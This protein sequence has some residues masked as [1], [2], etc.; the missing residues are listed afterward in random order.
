MKILFIKEK[1]SE[2]GLEGIASYLLNIC[3]EL[4]RLGIDYL[5]LYNARDL[6]YKKMVDNEVKVKL[7]SLPPSSVYNI[8]H[9]YL[10]VL[11]IRKLIHSIVLKE[12]ISLINVHFPHLL[13]YVSPSWDIP[14][15][16]HWH[17]AFVENKPLRY[18]DSENYL[19]LNAL[20]RNIY[21]RHRIYNFSNATKIICPSTAAKNT[22]TE[23][24]LVPENK[25]QM[26][27]YGVK[28]IYP[29]KY[30]DLRKKLGFNSTDKI[31]LSAG[32]ETRS[33]GVED[34][35]NVA[36]SLKERK[37]YKFV[38]LGGYRDKKYHDY[39][40]ESYGDVVSFM[41][42]REDINNF[43]RSAD[44][45]LFLS[46]RESA[47]LVLAE[48]MFFSLPIV[49]WDIIGVNEMFVNEKNGYLCDFSDIEQVA[50]KVV[51]V[52]D[53]E[54]LYKN[55]SEL[56]LKESSNHT[57]EKSVKNLINLFNMSC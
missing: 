13:Q 3:I 48:A 43:Y 31:I 46:H 4:D 41:G 49:A 12:K 7:V 33:K 30:L 32:R 57:I 51:T 37:D 8:F 44:L 10:D 27:A 5:V 45:F 29:S 17:G 1:R 19:N 55:F 40:V 9:K 36:L 42:M 35:C 53:N 34:F 56:S 39:L 23:C 25:I 20:I 2:S 38:F 16:A 24:F 52:L 47:G 6:F 14:I 15:F 11:K 26:N 28:K 54:W 18:F 21:Q 50:N 22:A